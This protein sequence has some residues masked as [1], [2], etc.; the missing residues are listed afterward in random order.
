MLNPAEHVILNA[1]K[2]KKISVFQA[3]INIDCYFYCS[4]TFMSRKKSCSAR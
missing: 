4:Y 2:L 3:Q 1:D